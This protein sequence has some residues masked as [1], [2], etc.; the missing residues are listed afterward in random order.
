MSIW[1][2]Y[3]AAASSIGALLAVPVLILTTRFRASSLIS[4]IALVFW[5]GASIAF[6]WIWFIVTIAAHKID[7]SLTMTWILAN[8]GYP[9]VGLGI[10]LAHRSVQRKL[11]R[12]SHG[13]V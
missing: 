5:G 12:R 11:G 8:L 4:V 10:V 13:A 7:D 6:A 1:I 2:I 3:L 9:L